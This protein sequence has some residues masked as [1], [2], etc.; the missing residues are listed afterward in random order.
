MTYYPIPSLSIE[1]AG[2][3][4]LARRQAVER[5]D[6]DAPYDEMRTSEAWLRKLGFEEEKRWV[7]LYFPQYPEKVAL[8]VV[9]KFR[10][11]PSAIPNILRGLKYDTLNGCWYFIHG[12][13]W[14]GVE[15]DGYIHT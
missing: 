9:Q 6:N 4:E 14:H 8:A 12:G 1:L 13:I 10:D 15:D 3:L 2:R 5:N 11:C 7:A